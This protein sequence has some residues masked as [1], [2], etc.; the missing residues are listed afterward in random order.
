MSNI[1]AQQRT[2]D[3][4]DFEVQPLPAMKSLETFPRITAMLAP[5]LADLG[6][7]SKASDSE[8]AA[9]VGKALSALAKTDAKELVSLTKVLLSE[10]TV[11]VDGKRQH[12]MPAFDTLMAGRLL[13]TFKLIAFAVEVNY[14]DFFDVFRGALGRVRGGFNSIFPIASE[15]AGSPGV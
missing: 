9:L 6:T 1:E 4:M 12:L 8:R 11:V 2:I 14:R 15:D 7:I 3:G 5:V 13:T 10:A